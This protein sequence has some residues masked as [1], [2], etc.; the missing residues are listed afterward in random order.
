[1]PT[2]Y[3]I[4]CSQAIEQ[5]TAALTGPV[6]ID[7]F[8][9]RVL[10]LWPST[11]KSAKTSIRNAMRYDYGETLLFVDKNTLIS[12]SV[13]MR[14]VTFRVP[15][16][17]EFAE[18]GLLPLYSSFVG[19]L[20]RWVETDKL[21]ISF[22]DAAGRPIPAPMTTREFTS[23]SAFGTHTGEMNVFD[24]TE[25]RLS[26]K[27]KTGD[28]LLLTVE[29][30]DKHQFQLVHEPAAVTQN[31]RQEIE[32]R[33][34][35]FADLLFEMLESARDETIW[36]SEA[37]LTT[38]IRLSDPTGYPG[39]HWLDVL[40]QDERMVWDGSYIRYADSWDN[41]FDAFFDDA[42]DNEAATPELSDTEAQQVYCF[43]AALWHRPGLWRRIEIQGGQ[44]LGE[45]HR[46]LVDAFN[47]DWDHMGGFWKRVRR[48]NSKRFREVDLGNIDP[49]GEGEAADVLMAGLELA[50]GSQLKY[51][52]DFGDWIEHKITLE[53][54]EAPDKTATYPRVAAQNKPRY[55]YCRHCKGDGKKSVAT[56]ICIDCS[57][58][59]QKDVLVCETCLDKYHSGHYDSELVY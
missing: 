3:K 51:V 46:L 7:E 50:P 28:S 53:A 5:V 6:T 25:W 34:Q 38:H 58:R 27:I 45:L 1:M 2:E 12:T 48:G 55:R 37:V 31:H 54:V 57:N 56:R 19:L 10:K 20:P 14:G 17:E 29:D 24:L 26:D 32:L 9:D 59:E 52:H 18:T 21:D 22:V 40:A 15:V 36:G 44:T 11:A 8:Y 47:H 43:K 39:N 41:P 13:A 33:N 4:S 23:E 35:A 16:G 42:D 30:W 49:F